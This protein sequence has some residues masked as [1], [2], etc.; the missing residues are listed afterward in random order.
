MGPVTS[1]CWDPSSPRL[2]LSWRGR[3]RIECGNAR[4]SAAADGCSSTKA[5]LWTDGGVRWETA[6]IERRRDGITCD[7][8]LISATRTS[9]GFHPTSTARST[10]SWTTMC[11]ASWQRRKRSGS[12]SWERSALRY[13]PRKIGE[14]SG[15]NRGQLHCH[16]NWPS[17]SPP[18]RAKKRTGWTGGQILTCEGSDLP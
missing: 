3:R 8:V 16:L 9:S 5:G 13:S 18:I 1:I 15:V 7:H 11:S 12:F 17:S 14:R 4:M 2:R 6:E 10:R